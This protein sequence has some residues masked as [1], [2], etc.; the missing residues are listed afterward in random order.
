MV[1]ILKTTYRWKPVFQRLAHRQDDF[2]VRIG[3]QELT[4]VLGDENGGS[5]S[6]SRIAT[7]AEGVPK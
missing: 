7:E 2:G 1:Q 6:P 3:F 5:S 4:S